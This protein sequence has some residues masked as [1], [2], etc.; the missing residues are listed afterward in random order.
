[1]VRRGP[2]NRPGGGG[3]SATYAGE[4]WRE[5]ALRITAIAVHKQDAFAEEVINTELDKVLDQDKPVPL[6]LSDAARL[7]ARRA[8]R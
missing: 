7:L 8:H 4:L 6:A 2:G 3:E 1:M 5:A